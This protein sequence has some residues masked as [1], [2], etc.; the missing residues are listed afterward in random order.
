MLFK[1]NSKRS[2]MIQNKLDKWR[3]PQ[4][5]QQ[6]QETINKTGEKEEDRK[7]NHLLSVLVFSLLLFD[8]KTNSSL[9]ILL[10]FF[11]ILFCPSCLAWSHI[12]GT[13]WGL[14][15]T[16]NS[17]LV[18]RLQQNRWASYLGFSCES[19]G[20]KRQMFLPNNF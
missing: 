7:E 8:F 18:F 5:Q 17:K 15:C 16:N 13:F 14:F 12:F 4:Q 10:V 20:K 9:N 1:G 19:R 11:F 6:Q 3:Q 2:K